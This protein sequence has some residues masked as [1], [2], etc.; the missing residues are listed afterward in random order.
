[1]IVD[2][3]FVVIYGDVGFFEI[4]VCCVGCV[5]CGDQD[6]VGFDGLCFVDY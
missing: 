4:E 5:V 3:D 6:V 2:D 1:M